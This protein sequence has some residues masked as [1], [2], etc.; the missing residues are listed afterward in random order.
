MT[1]TPWNLTHGQWSKNLTTIYFKLDFQ[2]L[3]ENSKYGQKTSKKSPNLK[4]L[5]GY[6]WSRK[7]A[8][9]GKVTEKGQT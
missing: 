5:G 2:Q 8:I 9:F 1:M 3:L 7:A 6:K 4:T